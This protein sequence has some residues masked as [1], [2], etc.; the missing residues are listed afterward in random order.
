[1]LNEEI[2]H[3][4]RLTCLEWSKIERVLMD[5]DE[6]DLADEII[7]QTFNKRKGTESREQINIELT[8]EDFDKIII[9]LGN[10]ESIAY[11]DLSME[12]FNQIQQEI[13]HHNGISEFM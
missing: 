10:K 3:S 8:Y 4:V 9:A 12:I 6:M 7:D 11:H 2:K 5:S 13:D 1:M